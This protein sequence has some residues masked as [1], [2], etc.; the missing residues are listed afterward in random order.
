MRIQKVEP[1]LPLAELVKADEPD[2]LAEGRLLHTAVPTGS[3]R[4]VVHHRTY[5]GYSGAR[6][7]NAAA[8]KLNEGGIAQVLRYAAAL[9]Q[10]PIC[11]GG[12]FNDN[13]ETSPTMHA[14]L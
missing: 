14:A 2:L 6:A 12:D 10:V 11:L 4:T 5:Y 9:G 7:G 13:P 1:P 8:K 3:G